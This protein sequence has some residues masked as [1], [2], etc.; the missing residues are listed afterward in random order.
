MLYSLIARRLTDVPAGSFPTGVTRFSDTLR[1]VF[2]DLTEVT[3]AHLPAF[4]ADDVVIADNHL[5]MLVPETTPCVVVHHGCAAT[6]AERDVSW[7]GQHI[8]RM[9]SDQGRM[10]YVPRRVFVAPSAWVRGEFAR[11][12]GLKP[13]YA[14]VIVNWVP[15][16]IGIPCSNER[17]RVVLG[18]W[19]DTNKGSAWAAELRRELPEFE[20]RALR[21][22]TVAEREDA[23]R[24]ADAYLCLS[25]SEGGSYSVCD[26]EAI[27]MPLVS[28]D[29]G[30]AREFEARLIGLDAAPD[31][32][33]DA[34]SFVIAEH[35][36]CSYFDTYTFERWAEDW[37]EVVEVARCA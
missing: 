2:P 9:I 31:V 11:H 21:C 3:P 17:R 7:R 34:L 18:D 15:P 25:Q 20:F 12:Y 8:D 26:A 36:G 19:R 33:R 13:D 14:R 16:I 4:T 37:R 5:S 23:Y 6:H 22:R 10:L 28:T 35:D 24:G 29:V 1:R 30:N 32:I 27:G